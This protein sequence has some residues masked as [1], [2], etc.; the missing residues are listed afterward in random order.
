[1]ENDLKI[2]SEDERNWGIFCHISPFAGYLIPL[3]NIILPLVLWLVKKEQSSFIDEVGKEIVN[4]QISISLYA[5]I[6]TALILL[7]IGLPLLIA[8]GIFNIVVI[9]LGAVAASKG[10]VYYFPLNIRFIQQ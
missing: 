4:F 9:I 2:I 1:M 6:A 3:G 10:E 8:I 7:L 5:I